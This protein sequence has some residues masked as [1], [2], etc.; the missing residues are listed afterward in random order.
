MPPTKPSS[1][2]VREQIRTALASHPVR[3]VARA[4]KL[5][6]ATVNSLAL[7][8]ELSRAHP[9]SLAQARQNA[10]ALLT[11]TA[12]EMTPSR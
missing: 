4:L 11:L 1:P 6:P 2:D 3:V 5:A 7:P 10:G 12:S 8:D 9:G